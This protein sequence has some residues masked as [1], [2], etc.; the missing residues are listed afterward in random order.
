MTSPVPTDETARRAHLMAQAERLRLEMEDLAGQVPALVVAQP[1]VKLLAYVLSLF[2]MANMSAFDEKEGPDRDVLKTFQFVLEYLHAVWSSH[3]PLADELID[4]DEPGVTALMEVLERLS[5]TTMMYC[6][7]SSAAVVD[8]RSA[9]TEFHAK[10][11]WA[12]IRGHRYQV[13]EDEFFTYVLAPHA[14]ALREAY[15]MEPEA[16]AKGL[17]NI[18]D[19]FRS[20]FSDAV[21][22]LFAGFDRAMAQVEATG[23]DMGA[24]VKE[25][26]ETDPNYMAGLSAS[27]QDMFFGGVCN[28]SRHSS[29]SVALLEDLSFEP[30]QDDRFF[31]PGEFSGTPM[32][33]LP[34]R[35]RPGIKLGDDFYSTDGQFIRDSAYR[36]IQWGL[37]KRLPYRDEWLKRQA[38]VVEQAFPA[39]FASQ[40][41]GAQIYE[42]VYYRDPKTGDWAETDL[43]IALDDV[44]VVVEAKAGVMPMQSPATNFASHE[45]VIQDLIVKAYRQC[46]R[47]LEYLASQPEA[48]LFHLVDGEYVEIGRLRKARFRLLLPIGLTVEAFTPFSAMAKELPEVTPILD[49]HP[50]MSMSVDDLFVL[51]RFLPTTGELIHYLE[52]RQAV[53]GLPNALLFD[54]TD[55][56]GAYV[57]GNRFDYDIKEQL[58]TADMVTWSHFS[59]LVDRH[60]EG[61]DWSDRPVPAQD[62]PEMMQALLDGLARIRPAGWLEMDG[63]LRDM[64]GD[65][66]DALAQTISD[67]VPT[68]AQHP[69]RCLQL[70]DEDPIQIWVCRLGAYPS[71]AEL[72]RHAEAGCLMGDARKM[73]VMVATFDPQGKVVGLTCASIAAPSVLRNDYAAVKAEAEQLRARAVPLAQPKDAK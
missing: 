53:A 10:S 13:L 55:H 43:I 22:N 36:A 46:R 38:R 51:T 3:S 39:I 12:L 28:L 15:G 35:T 18:S 7:A 20:G 50:F 64:S 71:E 6:M 2:Q 65:L 19:A 66:R 16:I 47:F 4:L 72:H 63:H 32:R 34:G 27:A 48:P 33:T 26:S 67:L 69:R 24:V 8:G 58:K 54:E 70:G 41:D 44:L 73:A 40:L 45:R 1:P 11:S 42:S 23:A 37:W 62:F 9:Q 29:L 57:S 56:L 21:E 68:L 52:V 30:G 17:Q 59:D 14:E 60:F 61:P 49:A 5:T 31:A 25:L